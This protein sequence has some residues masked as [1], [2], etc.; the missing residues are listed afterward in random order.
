MANTPNSNVSP[1]LAVLGHADLTTISASTTRGPILN[2]NVT[3][4]PMFGVVLIPTT[5]ADTKIS[6]ITLKGNSVSI[7]TP[8]VPTIIG[9]WINNGTTAYLEKEIVVTAVTPN[10]T[11]TASYESD[12]LYDDMVIPINSSVYVTSTVANPLLNVS[13]HGAS[14]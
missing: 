1:Q 11:T 7:A 10:S 14:M 3:L 4:T 12:T 2:A 6:K 13:A 5:T 9:L 8:N